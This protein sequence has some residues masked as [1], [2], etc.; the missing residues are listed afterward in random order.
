M[1]GEENAT[2]ADIMAVGQ[3]FFAASYRHEHFGDSNS[4]QSVHRKQG[5]PQRIM[6]L[7]P[8]DTNI[9]L[10]VRRAHL[11]MLLWKA[12]DQQGPP[13]VSISEYDWK[14]DAG[15]TPALTVVHQ[16]HRF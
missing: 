1:L 3:L 11:Q 2:H 16:D 8:T 6:L 5:K 15:I 12:T 14:I 9:Y 13:D 10:H 4:V 7:P